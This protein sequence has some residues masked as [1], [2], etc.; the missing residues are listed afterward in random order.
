MSTLQHPERW[1]LALIWLLI[2]G[3]I[4][5]RGYSASPLGFARRALAAGCKL[6]A[7]LMIAFCLLDPVIVREVPKIGANEVVI[8]ADNSASLAIA[9]RPGAKPRSEE[10]RGALLNADG[11]SEPAWLT[12]LRRDFRVRM[13]AIDDRSKTIPSGAA[14]TFSGTA[15]R[16]AS[17]AMDTRAVSAASKVAAVIL[18][19]D[20]LA[21]DQWP[22]TPL[23]AGA[24]VFPVLIG[25]ESP[26][27]DISLTE[28]TAAQ[29]AFEDSPVTLTVKLQQTGCQDRTVAV[30]ISGEDGKELAKETHRFDA[31]EPS[32]TLRIRVP[33]SRPGLS[34]LKAEASVS[35]VTEATLA[36]NSRWVA[37]DRGNGPYRVLY[38]GGRPNWD[39]KFLQRSLAADPEVQM[40]TLLRIARREPKFEW[41]GR[42]GETSNPLFKGFGAKGG[43]DVQRYDQPVLMRLNT[44]DAK[45]LLDGFPKKA[46]NLFA[47]YRAIILDDV[48][49]DFF[50]HE[51][52]S[53]IERFVSQRGG[54]LLM[55]GGQESFNLGHYDQTPVG[56]MLPVYVD[57]AQSGPPLMDAKL[58][59]TREGWLEPW[60]RLR[61][62]QSAEETRLATMAAFFSMN[63]TPTAKPGASILANVT[64]AAGQSTPVLS[65]Q[66]FGNGRVTAFGIGDLWRWGLKD[67]EQQADMQRFWR[68]LIRHLII[69]VPDRVTFSEVPSASEAERV[70]V[71][72]RDRAFEPQDDATV[73]LAIEH[74]GSPTATLSAEP[75]LTEGGVYE[76]AF[77]GR[78]SGTYRAKVLAKAQDGTL[79][80]EKESG[81]VRN[82]LADETQSLTP[83]RSWMQKIAQET[84]GRMLIPKELDELPMLVASLKLPAMERRITPVW[85]HPLYLLVILSLLIAEWLVRRMAGWL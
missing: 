3:F 45:E 27:T 22:E 5:L 37:V 23:P 48:E 1:P 64:D 38:V 72:V 8:L 20:G 41:R 85:H 68:Q 77:S 54:S 65:T 47:E 76:A 33:L 69:D 11:K 81:W 44:R 57:K 18:V 26:A 15:S 61:A 28:A 6:L 32:R 25:Q 51:Q 71:R 31:N 17:A 59:L 63:K 53:L 73:T 34:F 78:E 50:S 35:G 84:G 67:A 24:P 60:T 43:E 2:L 74:A 36:N 55:L 56:R 14:M 12:A 58:G 40:P 46:D 13:L 83:N 4:L 82:S 52:M 21:T 39:Y 16:L 80:G 19:S 79:I 75:S 49:A 29:T 7:G 62:E 42:Q 30:R 9:E 66:R 70:Q 10:L